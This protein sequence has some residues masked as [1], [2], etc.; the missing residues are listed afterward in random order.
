MHRLSVFLIILIFFFAIGDFLFCDEQVPFKAKPSSQLSFMPSLESA[1]Q[2]AR[3]SGKPVVVAFITDRCPLC[4]QL[5]KKVFRNTEVLALADDFH[6]VLVDLDRNLT[7]A[8]DQ[9]VE[10]VPLIQLLDPEGKK[11]KEILGLLEPVEFRD[12]LI[13]FR[14]TLQKLTSAEELIDQVSEKERAKRSLH[15]KPKGYR[16][17]SVCFSHVGYGPLHL[18]SQSPFQ[19]LRFGM[20]PR[21]PSTIS[22]GQFEFLSTLTWANIWN[23][24][25]ALDNEMKDYY[26]DFESLQTSFALAYGITDTVEIEGEFHHRSRFG[27]Y[28]DGMTQWFHDLFGIDQNARDKA[29]KSDFVFQL[30]PPHQRPEVILNGSDRGTF[31]RSLQVSLQHNVS[32]GTKR[33]PAFSYSMTARWETA[34]PGDFEGGN[35]FDLSASVALSRKFGK[36][37]LYGTLGHAWLGRDNFRGLKMKDNQSSGILALE[38]KYSL[39]KSILLQHLWTEGLIENFGPFSDPSNEI[40][41]GWKWEFLEGSILE[42]GIIENIFSYDNSPDFGIHIGYSQRF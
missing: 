22:R 10:A 5:R 15:Q 9:S 34:D 16:G 28:M 11:R 14:D 4:Q 21:T 12:A 31:V 20:R 33:F 37:Y 35:D 25:G 42:I 41:L 23:I 13:R 38:W 27:G 39:N 36:F 30:N 32:C 18:Y 26:L 40:T 8:R 3:A 24:D 6:W 17:K 1:K 2:A 29:P 19:A 7:M